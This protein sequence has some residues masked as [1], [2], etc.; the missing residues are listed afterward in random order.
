MLFS[1]VFLAGASLLSLAS[2]SPVARD[3]THGGFCITDSDAASLSASF[4]SLII[5]YNKTVADTVLTTDFQDWS[6]SI[7]FLTGAPVRPDYLPTT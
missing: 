4:A 5:K 6:S 1:T 2:A 3:D 7:N